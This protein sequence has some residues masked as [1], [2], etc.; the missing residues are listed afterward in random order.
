MKK[1]EEGGMSG[2]FEL[3][4]LFGLTQLR[5]PA[6]FTFGV[7]LTAFPIRLRASKVEISAYLSGGNTS[8]KIRYTTDGLGYPTSVS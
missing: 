8:R 1:L 6:C 2:S 5:H 7:L 3:L 4:S